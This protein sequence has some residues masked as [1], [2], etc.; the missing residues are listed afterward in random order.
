MT[1][2][3]SVTSSTSSIGS[4]MGGVVGGDAGWKL[5]TEGSSLVE[6]GVVIFATYQHA[7]VV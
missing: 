5:F 6:E 7:L 2:Q 3:G 1:S 4:K